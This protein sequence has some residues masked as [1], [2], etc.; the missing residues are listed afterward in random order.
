MLPAQIPQD[1][2]D[3]I[4]DQLS[5]LEDIST[6]RQ[7]AVVSRA[8]LSPVRQRLFSAISLAHP[9]QRNEKQCERLCEV[10]SDHPN[11]LHYIKKLRVVELMKRGEKH[12]TILRLLKMI[13]EHSDLQELQ[14]SAISPRDMRK[15]EHRLPLG[16][17]QGITQLAQTPSL[18]SIILFPWCHCNFPL[19]YIVTPPLL[20]HLGIVGPV[21][22]FISSDHAEPTLPPPTP[23][24]PRLLES[25]TIG[26]S[27]SRLV[28]K[29]LTTPRFPLSISR[30]RSLTLFKSHNFI[31]GPVAEVVQLASRSLECLVWEFPDCEKSG[32]ESTSE[33]AWYHPINFRLLTN[34]RTLIIVSLHELGQLNTARDLIGGPHRISGASRLEHLV[35]LLMNGSPTQSGQT[36]VTDVNEKIETVKLDEALASVCRTATFRGRITVW[37]FVS[38]PEDIDTD[39]HPAKGLGRFDSRLAKMFPLTS[40]CDVPIEGAFGEKT[41]SSGVLKRLQQEAL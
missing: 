33:I 41:Q 17:L 36:A 25:L 1:V 15:D 13:A 35:I 19:D 34:L 9:T 18:R 21:T 12:E 8:C 39:L 4:I 16:L 26:G 7:F 24:S 28:V 27:T 20:K 5:N 11:I 3:S 37:I 14:F 23:S 38:R 31:L 22:E 40:A 30:I 29:C 2:L 6:L 10:L 32:N